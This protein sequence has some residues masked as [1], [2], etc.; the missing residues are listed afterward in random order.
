MRSLLLVLALAVPAALTT[1]AT[2]GTSHTTCSA[3]HLSRALPKQNVPA[4]V[5]ATR[6]RIVAAAIACDYAKLERIGRER[7]SFSF[8]FGGGSSATAYWRAEEKRG[9]KPLATLVRILRLP[10]TRNET[11]AYA[12]PSAYTDHPTRADWDALVRAGVLT[13]AQATAQRTHGNVYYGYRAAIAKN[14]DWQF[15][16]AGD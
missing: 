6:Q 8:S 16:V 7:G 10:V 5:A 4:A 2:A 1:V 13:R 11:R 14:G 15:F 3:G 9:G 12:W